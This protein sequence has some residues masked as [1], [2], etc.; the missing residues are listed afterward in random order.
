[1]ASQIKF[2]AVFFSIFSAPPL[3]LSINRINTSFEGVPFFSVMLFVRFLLFFLLVILSSSSSAILQEVKNE[4]RTSRM[5]LC[6]IQPT[7]KAIG[8]RR[9]R[10][11]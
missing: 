10:E 11:D 7:K 3:S 9:K 6:A 8:N 2:R 5:F 1:M 4:R